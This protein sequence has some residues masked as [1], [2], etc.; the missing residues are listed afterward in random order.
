MSKAKK[1]AASKTEST[2][3][4]H[5]WVLIS[6]IPQKDKSGTFAP[7]RCSNCD[8][9]YKKRGEKL[10][11]PM[12]AC[13]KKP[14]TTKLAKPTRFKATLEEANKR[15]KEVKEK[16]AVMGK[17][18]WELGAEVKACIDDYIPEALGKKAT[19]WM[20][21]CF[22]DSWLRVYRA[23]RAIA[24]LP[25]VSKEKLEKISEGN[26]YQLAR[27]PEN[28]R[29]SEEWIDKAGKLENEKF[30]EAVEKQREKKGVK[31]DPMV[32]LFDIFRIN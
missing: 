10:N 4:K 16:F 23:H 28:I 26:A 25:G 5:Q 11:F 18:W 7:Y 27:L 22:G 3:A 12:S 8:A 21:E 1:S 13:A 15:T 32:K 9:Y 29:K 17:L 20:K 14:K 31:K 6:K 30:K 24:A 2:G 19:E